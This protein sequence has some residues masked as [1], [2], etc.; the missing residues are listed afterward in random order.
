MKR[1]FRILGVVVLALLLT[2]GCAG[3]K[4]PGAT[5]GEEQ[6][7]AT[8]EGQKV[9]SEDKKSQT[10]LPSDKELGIIHPIHLAE[11]M[12]I[13]DAQEELNM[14]TFEVPYELDENHKI[15]MESLLARWKIFARLFEKTD[16]DGT[17]GS[18]YELVGVGYYDLEKQ[19][20][21]PIAKL[22]EGPFEDSNDL[23]NVYFY[24]IDDDRCLGA[25]A[26]QYYV[27]QFE[28]K[29]VMEIAEFA[30]SGGRPYVTTDAIYIPER[31]GDD[32]VRVHAYDSHTYQ[33]IA[34]Y[35]GG[36]KWLP[37]K[38]NGIAMRERRGKPG[39]SVMELSLEGETYV[40][41]QKEGKSL[42]DFGITSDPDAVYVL[43]YSF[44]TN[45][46]DE[47]LTEHDREN[48]ENVPYYCIQK[49]PEME[50][51]VRVRGAYINMWTSGPWMGIGKPYYYPD[52]STDPS[53]ILI[54][55]EKRALRVTLP[56]PTKGPTLLPFDRVAAFYSVPERNGEIPDSLTI[57]TFEP[58]DKAQ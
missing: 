36:D 32:E 6:D 38:E 56:Q 3:E 5:T 34:T 2:V 52:G 26:G 33:E 25:S 12:E 17:P 43:S 47:D 45:E 48:P 46:L 50:D 1:K 29:S 40:W 23:M 10:P 8:V 49:Y 4:T 15:N 27:Y 37:W 57:Y 7:H 30:R 51:L 18:D 13:Y 55:G 35:T 42:G 11:G 19:E 16:G 53:Y 22:G 20:M 41:K 58:K 9:T 31:V 28:D 14:R 24:P 21:V 54:P 39:E 44:G